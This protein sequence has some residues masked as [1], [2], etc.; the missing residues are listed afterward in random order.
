M[1][2]RVRPH[3]Q[4]IKD[5][6]D[7]C[8]IYPY[9]LRRFRAKTTSESCRIICAVSSRRALHLRESER[10]RRG[11]EFR[12]KTVKMLKIKSVWNNILF[13]NTHFM[14]VLEAGWQVRDGSA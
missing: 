10:A 14:G 3:L 12:R 6:G 1:S 8:L 5:P 7:A 9:R 2:K 13:V 4:P 11:T